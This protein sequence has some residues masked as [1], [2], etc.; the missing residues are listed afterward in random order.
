ME[1]HRIKADFVEAV[2]IE[3][4]STKDHVG[5]LERLAYAIEAT[6][7]QFPDVNINEAIIVFLEAEWEER[8]EGEDATASSQ[9][10]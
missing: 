3:D 2:L 9:Q 5:G 7:E 8:M 4:K 10:E 1:A 6:V